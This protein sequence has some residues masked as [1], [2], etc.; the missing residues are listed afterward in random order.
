VYVP[1]LNLPGSVEEVC[2]AEEVTESAET[3]VCPA[4]DAALA[5]KVPI[6]LVATWF[7]AASVTSTV[8]KPS[9]A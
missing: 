9:R 2:V 3:I 8:N 6:A 1:V 4:R 5:E 7:P